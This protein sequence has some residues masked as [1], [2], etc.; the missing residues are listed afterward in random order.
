M[1]GAAPQVTAVE[2]IRN[3]GPDL[4]RNPSE[5]ALASMMRA[6]ISGNIPRFTATEAE[7]GKTRRRD[8]RIE[9]TDDEGNPRA[10]TLDAA[11]GRWDVDNPPANG[12]QV[13]DAISA[14]EKMLEA[15]SEG[16]NIRAF[17]TGD[18][19]GVIS[20]DRQSKGNHPAVVMQRLGT[21]VAFYYEAPDEFGTDGRQYD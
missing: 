5:A 11:K 2:E 12:P 18:G 8:A 21:T 4:E 17:R 13:Q 10:F 9:W 19:L 20:W 6:C 16:W 3:P 14:V 1:N 15:V 7:Q